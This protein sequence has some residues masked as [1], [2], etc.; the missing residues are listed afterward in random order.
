MKR[1]GPAILALSAAVGVLFALGSV[2][3]AAA[4]HAEADFSLTAQPVADGEWLLEARLRDR[5]SGAI[6]LQLVRFSAT[7]EFLGTRRVLL[8]TVETDTSG[9][10]RLTYRPTWSG[11]QRIVARASFDDGTAASNEAVLE[12]DDAVSPLAPL[13]ARLTVVGSWAGPVA[14]TVALSVWGLLALVL[15]RVVFGISRAPAVTATGRRPERQGRFGRRPL[16]RSGSSMR[17]DRP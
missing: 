4:S 3:R 17:E 8:G 6:G 1:R 2:G 14:A 5:S 13:P 16:G 12:I 9:T 10:A 15:L 11:L 7:V